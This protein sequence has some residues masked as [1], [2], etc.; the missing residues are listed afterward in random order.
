MILVIIQIYRLQLS[1]VASFAF[2]IC[3]EFVQILMFYFLEMSIAFYP[4][5]LNM[6]ITRYMIPFT[7]T[8]KFRVYLDLEYQLILL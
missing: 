6:E 2:S 4:N 1:I 8:M 3:F 7:Q 5:I